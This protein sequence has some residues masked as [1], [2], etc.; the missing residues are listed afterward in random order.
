MRR[1]RPLRAFSII[2]STRYPRAAL[3]EDVV[4]HALATSI[5]ADELSRLELLDLVNWPTATRARYAALRAS[6]AFVVAPERAD[7][8]YRREF[9]RFRARRLRVVAGTRGVRDAARSGV[10]RRLHEMVVARLGALRFAIP[11]AKRSRIFFASRRPK[12]IFMSSRNGSPVSPTP[13]ANAFAGTP[14]C[15]SA[16]S[17][18]SRSAWR[19]RAANARACSATFCTAFRSARRPITTIRRGRVGA[20]SVFRLAAS[21]KRN[22]RPSSRRCARDCVTLAAFASTT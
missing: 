1:I 10:R 9:E 14:A 21:R 2:R 20:S 12:S 15:A 18:T 17:R 8:P 3:P 19:P 16:S 6:N 13:T 7:E 22:S 5:S 11:R 4:R